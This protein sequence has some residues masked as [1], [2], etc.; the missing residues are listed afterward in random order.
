MTVLLKLLFGVLAFL[1][2][3]WILGAVGLGD[4]IRLLLSILI[5]LLVVGYAP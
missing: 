4:P 2:S 5:A 3:E 1:V